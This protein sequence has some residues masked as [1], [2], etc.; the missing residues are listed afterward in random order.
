M[1]SIRSKITRK[2]LEYFFLNPH[3][4]HYVNELARMFSV[5]PKNLHKKL[6]ALE[7]EGLLLSEFSGKQR[8]FSLREHYPLLKEYRAIIFKTSLERRLKDILLR[9]PGVASAYLFGSYVRGNMDAASDI[10]ML[11]VGNHSI[12]ALQKELNVLQKETGR[13]INAVQMSE[14]EFLKKRKKGNPFLV[15]ILKKEHIQL[16]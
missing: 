8:Y 6:E 4:R 12:A 1:I 13:E 9:I 11:V 10:D 15:R 7:R 2:I 3:A 5:D 16:V 14:K